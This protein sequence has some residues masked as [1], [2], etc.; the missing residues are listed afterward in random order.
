MPSAAP[1]RKRTV[2]HLHKAKKP[3]R[4]RKQKNYHSSSEDENESD[5]AEPDVTPVDMDDSGDDDQVAVSGAKNPS[6]TLTNPA[7]VPPNV[8]SVSDQEGSDNEDAEQADDIDLGDDSMADSNPS[9]DSESEAEIRAQSKTKKRNDPSAFATSMSKILSSK[10]STS[11]RSDP[12]L[13]RSVDAS[14]A[15]KELLDSRLELKA[16]QKMRA[17]KKAALQRGRVTDVLGL[18]TT[19]ISAAEVQERER[20]LK[21][22]AQRGVVKLFNAVRAAQVQADVARE[23]TKKEGIVG[24]AQREEKINEMSK[25]SFL[26]LIA[27]GG[28]KGATIEEG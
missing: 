25:Q 20:R 7:K 4:F 16:K 27:K 5:D 18:E 6:T 9:G 28:K 12:V 26:D 8:G 14:T 22:T 17:E 2:E 21:K 23:Q 1:K 11:K 19:G 10:L 3:K 15:N 24:M 13:S